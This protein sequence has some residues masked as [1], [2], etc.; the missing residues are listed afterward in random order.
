MTKKDYILIADIL[1][2]KLKEVRNWHNVEAVSLAIGY[3][4]DFAY[5]LQK[6]NPRFNRIKFVEYINKNY[7]SNLSYEKDIRELKTFA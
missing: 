4:D 1:G 2:K 3:C 7:E 6:E 5:A